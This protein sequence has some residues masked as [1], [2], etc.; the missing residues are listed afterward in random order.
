MTIEFRLAAR[1]DRLH[2]PFE[3]FGVQGE[4]DLLDLTALLV[5]IVQKFPESL[6]SMEARAP[7][8]MSTSTR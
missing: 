8:P 7:S 6:D 5:R 2:G 4:A 1:P 3:H